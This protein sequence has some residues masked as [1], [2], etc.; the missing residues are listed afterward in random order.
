MESTE[1]FVHLSMMLCRSTRVF[2]PKC[3]AAFVFCSTVHTYHFL[4]Q[5]MYLVTSFSALSPPDS[6]DQH[7]PTKVWHYS[8]KQQTSR[9]GCH[10]SSSL[11]RYTKSSS[12]TLVSDSPLEKKRKRLKHAGPSSIRDLTLNRELLGESFKILISL[13][14]TQQCRGIC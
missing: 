6:S 4:R 14:L 1:R 5:Y 8:L 9:T 12:V 10:S 2:L 11:T 7:H 3:G 13:Q